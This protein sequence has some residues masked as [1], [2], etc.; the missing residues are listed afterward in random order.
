MNS[1]LQDI[2]GQPDAL[3]LALRACSGSLKPDLERAADRI[4]QA[5]R[6]V[7]TSMGSAYYSCQ[8]P[9]YALQALH[10]NV[11]LCETAD[12]L[13]RDVFP[14]SLTIILSRS[15]ES[16]EIAEYA[17]RIRA[18][19]G[20][21]IAVTMTP[22]STLAEAADLVIHNP[23]PFDGFICTKAYSTLTLIGLILARM[24]NE[25]FDDTLIQRLEQLFD[26]MEATQEEL[27]RQIGALP[28]LDRLDGVTLLSHGSGIATA[29]A[30]ALWIEEAARIRASV[31]SYSAFRHGPIEQV[32]PGFTA[33]A[34][35]LEPD[36][37]S[38]AARQELEA[39]G[40]RLITVSPEGEEDA[41]IALPLE[42][43]PAEFRPIAAAPTLQLCAHHAARL[44]GLNAGDMRYLNW[45]VK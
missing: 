10:P 16:G 14:D 31:S 3:R 11:Q 4:R 25:T 18:R 5:N 15:G 37:Q 26:H 30:G 40:A 17:R 39:R 41:T 36:A 8:P 35:D 1:F 12:L 33:I 45:V 2:Y 43:L 21:L 34:I 29:W 42:G 19:G 22:G 32:E 9:A 24:V 27:D 38:R 13:E 6:V 20:D 23:S 44:R 28:A 7:L